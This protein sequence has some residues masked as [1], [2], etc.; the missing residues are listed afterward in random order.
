M[1]IDLII[2][3]YTEATTIADIIKVAQASNLF[4]QVIVVDDGSADSTA[5]VAEA[6]GADV[7]IRVQPN[8]GKANA[9]RVGLDQVTAGLVLYWDADLVGTQAE[10]FSKLLDAFHGSSKM[11]VGVLPSFGQRVAPA[12]SGERLLTADTMRQFFAEHPNIQRFS[13]EQKITDW[14]KAN[15]WSIEYVPITGIRHRQKEEKRGFWRGLGDRL[16]MYRDI[17]TG[18]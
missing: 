9:M 10:H 14:F 2:P 3:A 16:A 11:V 4:G 8:A 7:V 17:V 5:D 12:W 18:R 15:N 13:V 6:A 1:T